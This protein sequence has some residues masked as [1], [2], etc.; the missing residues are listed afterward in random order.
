MENHSSRSQVGSFLGAEE[1]KVFHKSNRRNSWKCQS[2]IGCVG[3]NEK[4][5]FPALAFSQD[6]QCVHF[7]LGL[8]QKSWID[9]GNLGH[10]D[11]SGCSELCQ[12]SGL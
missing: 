2:L 10:W 4:T 7:L 12:I 11:L 9:W 5:V 8:L 6:L 3:K 1:S